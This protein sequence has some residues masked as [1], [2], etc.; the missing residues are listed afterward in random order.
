MR[1]KKKKRRLGK[2]KKNLIFRELLPLMLLLLLML[3]LQLL[4]FQ[5]TKR[6]GEVEEEFSH[7]AFSTVS[8]SQDAGIVLNALK[9]KKGLFPVETSPLELENY[10][11]NLK[12]DCPLFYAIDAVQFRRPICEN[13]ENNP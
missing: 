2:K 8:T 10:T 4:G 7:P 13:I 11:V 3:L 12:K 6:R 9:R 5:N 1:M